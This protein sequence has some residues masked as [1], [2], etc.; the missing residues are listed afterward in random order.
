MMWSI[1]FEF[2]QFPLAIHV[3]KRESGTTILYVPLV[4][5]HAFVVV[6]GIYCASL[7]SATSRLVHELSA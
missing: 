5:A 2:F 6:V 3:E 7:K 4:D 1:M